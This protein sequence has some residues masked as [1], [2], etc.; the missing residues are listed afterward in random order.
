MKVVNR[1]S[2]IP[3]RGHADELI[4]MLNAHG[5]DYP[6]RIYRSHYGQLNLVVSEHEFASIAEMEQAW[7]NWF[8]ADHTKDFLQRWYSITKPGGTNEV[9]ILDE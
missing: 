7:S 1:R 6:M 8:A 4:S 2:Y 9:W 3:K 5:S